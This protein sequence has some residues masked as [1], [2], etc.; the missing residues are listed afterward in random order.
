MQTSTLRRQRRAV[1][2][3]H[4]FWRRRLLSAK[5]L[6]GFEC[7]GALVNGKLAASV[8]TF[9]MDDCCYMLYQQ[10]REEYLRE[11]VNNALSFTVTSEMMVRKN[12]KSVFYSLHS[13]DAP[14]GIDEFKFRMG[15][16]AKPVRQRVIFNPWRAQSFNSTSH[17]ILWAA[18]RLRPAIAT[19]AKAE[20]MVRFYLRGDLP[21]SQQP[22]PLHLK[23]SDHHLK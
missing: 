14:A 15:Y 22:L 8:M 23:E 9:Q 20:G 19:L 2:L 21:L 1:D 6:P 11:H 17:A 4:Q 12:I 5:D 16:T 18:L 7:W 3:D 13:L 10:C